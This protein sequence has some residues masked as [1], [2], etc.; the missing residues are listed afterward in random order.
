MADP[1]YNNTHR[2]FLQY[3]MAHQTTTFEDAKPRLAAILS[4]HEPDRPTLPEDVTA[5]DFEAYIDAI[6]TAIS[7]YDF[8]IRNA[9]DQKNPQTR[10]YALV[11][12]TSDVFAQLSTPHTPD[13]IA[14][15]KRVLDAMFETNNTRRAEVMAIASMQALKLAKTPA[16]EERRE[17][18]QG[19][20]TH[21]GLTQSQAERTMDSMVA[22]GWFEVSR[23]GFY[24]LTPRALMELK[25][26]L[27]ETYDDRDGEDEE[28]EDEVERTRIKFCAACR[29]IVTVGQR[30]PNLDC[31]GRVHDH[32]ARN[33]F[34]AQGGREE[35]PV[36]K[37]AWVDP[38]PVGEKAWRNAGGGGGR[39]STNG[40]SQANRRRTA[41][42]ELDV[43]S[44]AE[45][46]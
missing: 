15:V 32:C 23:K 13:E 25:G 6:H 26:W 12:T 2:A 40:T 29:E 16:S 28:G 4:A 1:S 30:C 44:G 14:F 11:N 17:E 27:V 36:C 21:A 9:L 10:V 19:L 22:E 33:L 18:G 24:S 38:P 8:E 41:D 34:R 31:L 43:E 37:R 7:P 35:C 46:G 3:L 20:A 42:T 45:E 39:R 5:D